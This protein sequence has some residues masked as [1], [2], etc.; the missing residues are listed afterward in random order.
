MSLERLQRRA[1]WRDVGLFC[2]DLC[3]ATG[4]GLSFSVFN[5][6]GAL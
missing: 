5:S 4:A 2:V 6:P 3:K 1:G